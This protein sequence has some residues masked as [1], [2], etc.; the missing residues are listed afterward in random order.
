MAHAEEGGPHRAHAEVL[1][2]WG[3]EATKGN[4]RRTEAIQVSLVRVYS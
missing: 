1:E 2:S 3:M 4:R